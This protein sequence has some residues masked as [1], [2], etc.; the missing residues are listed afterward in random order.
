MRSSLSPITGRATLSFLFA[1]LAFVQIVLSNW[2][3]YSLTWF[4]QTFCPLFSIWQLCR[5]VCAT[6]ILLIGVH[7]GDIF[8]V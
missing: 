5:E 1:F 7:N 6:P 4:Q 8:I 3:L 2:R